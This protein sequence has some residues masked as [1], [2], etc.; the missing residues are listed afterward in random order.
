[1]TTTNFRGR[2]ARLAAYT[3]AVA[4]A[5]C[6]VPVRTPAAADSP[7]ETGPFE[8]PGRTQCILARKFVIAPVPLHPVTEVLV[9][10]GSRV[11][12]GQPLVKLDDD[13]AQADVRA[14]QA[15][16][17]GA[18]I[19][20]AEARRYLAAVEKTLA[21]GTVPEQRYHE[22][23][24]AA[25]KADSDEK[26]AKAAFEAARAELEHFELTAPFDGVIS[27]L[28]VHPGMV[29]RPGT[30]VWGE[31]LDLREIDIRCEVA[32]DHVDRVSIGQSA[33]VRK[34][35]H[36]E[37]IGSGKVVFVGVSSDPRTDLVPVHVRFANPDGKL[38]CGEPVT[39]RYAP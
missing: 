23:R 16:L 10:P 24:A 5:T 13:E 30:T 11:K 4:L 39:V 37:A 26:S 3:A 8:V 19:A 6:A 32:F 28:E 2:S 15:A 29:S 38:R 34:K 18:T 12:K 14:R 7:G 33:E 31:V 1:M 35:S 25:L 9:E 21:S 17:E 20:H 36:K 27:W 22:V